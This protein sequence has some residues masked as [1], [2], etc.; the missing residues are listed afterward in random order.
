MTQFYVRSVSGVTWSDRE[1]S[2]A[3]RSQY[4]KAANPGADT[5]RTF[6]LAGLMVFTDARV[7]QYP[8][9]G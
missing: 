1:G 9:T 4:F 2:K 6:H 8:D 5:K 7:S 3:D